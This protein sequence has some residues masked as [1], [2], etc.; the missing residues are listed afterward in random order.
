V[1]A[2][3]RLLLVGH[4]GR[5][6]GVAGEV[7]VVPIS[8]D[9]NRFSPGA[10]LLHEGAGPLVIVSS[11]GQGERLLVRFEGVD[12]RSAAEG[13]RGALFVEESDL[14]V[15]EPGEYWHH[16]LAGCEV[17]DPTGSP[18]GRVERVV[19][20]P[21]QD[22]LEVETPGGRR[23]VPLVKEIVVEVDVAARRVVVDAPPGLLGPS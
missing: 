12:T 16:E 8:D 7:Y 2:P 10:R 21:A 13:L 15:L 1:T 18:L 11:R 14:R 23:L 19:P 22:L 17:R 5:P 3:P 4:V 20:G 6:H 9:P